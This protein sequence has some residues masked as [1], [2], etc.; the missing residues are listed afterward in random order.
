[1][2]VVLLVLLGLVVLGLAVLGL[3]ED[4]LQRVVMASFSWV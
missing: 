3:A 4:F 2:A 1:M